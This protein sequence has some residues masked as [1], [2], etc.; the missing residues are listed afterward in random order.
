MHASAGARGWGW[1]PD[2][3]PLTSPNPLVPIDSCQVT[4]VSVPQVKILWEKFF[5][6]NTGLYPS[7]LFYFLDHGTG[8]QPL[9]AFEPSPLTYTPGPLGVFLLWQFRQ[10]NGDIPMSLLEFYTA[11]MWVLAVYISAYQLS[12]LG[13]QPLGHNVALLVPLALLGYCFWIFVLEW[14]LFFA[15]WVSINNAYQIYKLLPAKRKPQATPTDRAKQ[16]I[17]HHPV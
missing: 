9:F 6:N 2:C 5:V 1:L 15:I 17:M 16:H 4:G 10:L 12:T 7:A 11:T 3:R 13:R 8:L 14:T